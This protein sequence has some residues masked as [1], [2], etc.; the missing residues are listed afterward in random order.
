MPGF[1]AFVSVCWLLLVPN[2]L[3]QASIPTETFQQALL[4]GAR[5]RAHSFAAS[6]SLTPTVRAS[7][8]SISEWQKLTWTF[9]NYYVYFCLLYSFPLSSVAHVCWACAGRG[10]EGVG[11][12][13]YK[14]SSAPLRFIL[15]W[16]WLF[17]LKCFVKALPNDL[18]A[19]ERLNSG[20]IF[21]VWWRKSSAIIQNSK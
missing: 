7:A 6:V 12:T 9:F 11:R 15:V 13:S 1:G 14:S 10:A 8:V 5:N 21:C 19:G 16:K 2:P 4:L 3:R 18:L 17:L 20:K